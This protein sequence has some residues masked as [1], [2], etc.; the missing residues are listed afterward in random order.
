MQKDKIIKIISKK[1]YTEKIIINDKPYPFTENG[2]EYLI[3]KDNEAA[4]A[5]IFLSPRYF[6]KKAAK[7]IL[8]HTLDNIATAGGLNKKELKKELTGLHLSGE[9]HDGDIDIDLGQY[10]SLKSE[11]Y[12][13]KKLNFLFNTLYLAPMIIIAIIVLSFIIWAVGKIIF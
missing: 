13:S 11:P 5:E 12:I 7:K 2:N 9:I 3:S 10:N 4:K 6:E 1:Y 8:L